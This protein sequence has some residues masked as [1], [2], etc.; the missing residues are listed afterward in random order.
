MGR[1]EWT[2]SGF[3]ERTQTPRHRLTCGRRG[4]GKG[5]SASFDPW[6][7]RPPD[8][9][10]EHEGC[11]KVP[12]H[13]TVLTVT[14]AGRFADSL[15]C[16]D[17]VEGTGHRDCSYSKRQASVRGVK[18]IS[19]RSDPSRTPVFAAG[20]GVR[21][22]VPPCRTHLRTHLNEASLARARPDATCVF[23]LHRVRVGDAMPEGP[24]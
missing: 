9:T 4:S 14:V 22:I 8:G 10:Q 23:R 2:T 1:Q 15:V 24:R 18:C 13:V 17:V 20:K 7:H 6:Y 12:G 11:R 3:K 16:P 5:K 19:K 21:V